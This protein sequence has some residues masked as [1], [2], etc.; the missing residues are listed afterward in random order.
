MLEIIGATLANATA[1]AISPIPVIAVIL[2]LMS[3]RAV[4]MGVSFLAGWLLGILVA[5]TVF[6]PLADVVP[7][8]E[9]NGGSQPILGTAQL[10]LGAGL[11]LLAVKQWRGRPRDGETPELPAWMSKI[12]TMKPGA[13]F[14]LAVALA[15]VNPKNL[16]VAASAGATI[17][18][19]S[20]GMV[21]AIVPILVFTLIAGLSV[22]APVVIVLVARNAAGT[23]LTGIREWLTTNNAAIMTVVLVVLGAQVLGKGLAAF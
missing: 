18:R 9:T 15:A 3:P 22:L 6:T 16:L 8:P 14:V 21:E 19:G 12:D 5:T 4:T 2:M 1:I 7:E 23:A 13:A 20:G 17:G 11:L 10:V